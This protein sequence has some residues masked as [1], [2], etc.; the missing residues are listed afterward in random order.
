LQALHDGQEILVRARWADPTQDRQ[1]QPWRKTEQGWE[2][3]A[4][5]LS[6]ESYYYEDKFSLA[7][8]TQPNRK[9]ETFSC[10]ICCHVGGGRPYGFKGFESTIDVWHWKATRADPVGQID[11]KYWSE[12][13]FGVTN[14]RHGDPKTGGGYETNVAEDKAGPKCLPANAAAVRGGGILSDQA[15]PVDAPEA[16]EILAEMPVGA[17]VPGMLLAPFE[18][19][20]GDVHCQSRHEDG[21]WEVLIRR[22]LDTGS[23]FDAQFAPGGSYTFGCAAFDH[24]S[25]RHAY[26]FDTFALQLEP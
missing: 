1:Y 24:S 20:Q 9:F 19:D 13:E 7:F 21:Q 16:A 8:P 5:V 12:V 11:D 10:A 3:M 6:D 15:V 18:G 4:T 23:E 22:K 17:I 14:G 26:N 2:H 25:K